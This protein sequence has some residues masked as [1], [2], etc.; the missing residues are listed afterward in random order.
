MML[1]CMKPCSLTAAGL[2]VMNFEN[3]GAVMITFTDYQ[4][5]V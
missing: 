4:I 1:R 5:I 2:Y 3:Y